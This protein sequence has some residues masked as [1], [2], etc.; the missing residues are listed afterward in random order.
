MIRKSLKKRK[1]L[2]KK[3]RDKVWSYDGANFIYFMSSHIYVDK[4]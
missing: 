3:L 1:K 4:I 2:P